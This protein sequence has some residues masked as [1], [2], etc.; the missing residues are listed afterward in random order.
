MEK[1][2]EKVFTDAEMLRQKV[3]EGWEELDYNKDGK[4]EA[5][6]LMKIFDADGDG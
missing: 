3:S 6:D 1:E 2:E 5:S 4:I